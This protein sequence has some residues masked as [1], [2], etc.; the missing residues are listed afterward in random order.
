M[1]YG[2]LRNET[3]YIRWSREAEK[4][5]LSQDEYN[6]K[7]LSLR[8]LGG[9]ELDTYLTVRNNWRNGCF[10]AKGKDKMATIYT[11]ED[12][13]YYIYSTYFDQAK[14]EDNI[15]GS[16][17]Y[18]HINH[19]FQE[20]NKISLREAFGSGSS[21]IKTCVEA[22]SPMIGLDPRYY[23]KHFFHAYKADISSAYPAMICGKLPDCRKMKVLK[24][25]IEPT[26][27]YPFVFYPQTGHSRE[28]NGY[29]SED[30]IN[31]KW[32]KRFANFIEAEVT[33]T[34]AFGTSDYNLN[35]EIQSLYDLKAIDPDAKAIL[36]KFIG[37]MRSDKYN[38]TNYQGHIAA[39]VYGRHIKRMIEIADQ[40]EAERNIVIMFSTDSIIWQGHDSKTVEDKKLGAFVLEFADCE[41]Y[42]RSQGVYILV[43][44]NGKGAMVKH[45]GTIVDSP[46]NS[47]ND[48]IEFFSK[49]KNNRAW[50]YNPQT[51][52]FEYIDNGGRRYGI[53]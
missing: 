26:I 27:D 12:G 53:D 24:G 14:N 50:G 31:S 28:L 5:E 30:F 39:V 38:T 34:I 1:I 32:Y 18:R 46:I 16:V 23:E 29:N 22:L 37:F 17:A 40:L 44:K 43:D 48:F 52:L 41:A 9:K 11:K 36:N 19:L 47:I 42:I 8:N 35:P 3:R 49:E 2:N 7:L 6:Q 25:K 13:K 15:K 4:I 45:Q 33:Y 21:S 20:R 10:A 51:K